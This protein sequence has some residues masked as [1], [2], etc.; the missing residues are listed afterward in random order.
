MDVEQPIFQES[1]EATDKSLRR[2]ITIGRHSSTTEIEISEKSL[3]RAKK[4]PAKFWALEYLRGAKSKVM[5]EQPRGRKI[6]VLDLFCGTGGLALGFCETARSLGLE[7]EVVGCVDKDPVALSIYRHN[8]HPR[9]VFKENIDGLVDY[10]ISFVGD[11]PRFAYFPELIDEKLAQLIGKIDIVIGGPPCQGHSTLNNRTRHVDS[12]NSLYLTVPAIAIALG[13]EAVVIENVEGI[14]ADKGN[15]VE[16]A[17]SVLKHPAGDKSEYLVDELLLS[18]EKF[19]VPQTRKRHFLVASKKMPIS[20]KTLKSGLVTSN[21]TALDAIRDLVK[22][23]GKDDFNRTAGI[24]EENQK[25]INWL[26]DEDE[27]NLK[28]HMRPDCHKNGHTYP[29][30]YGRILKDKPAQT[31]TTGFLSPGR[32]RFTH[33]T[34]RRGLTPHEGARLQSFPDSYEFSDGKG[35]KLRMKDYSKLIGDAVPPLMSSTVALFTYV[36]MGDG[37]FS[38]SEE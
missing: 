32:G 25:R 27:T 24:S 1:F 33:P 23:E 12:R 31:I 5:G 38:R 7:I 19:N 34:K 14:R 13:A 20:F 22:T 10:Q 8:L 35:L 29:S 17:R 37:L 3:R 18:A 4:D 6:R 16:I 9:C 11:E 26:F 30:V 2:T 21:I 28:N 15:V 36:S